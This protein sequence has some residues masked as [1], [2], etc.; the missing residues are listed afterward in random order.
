MTSIPSFYVSVEDYHSI[1]DLYVKAR[2]R[3]VFS[4]L[5]LGEVISVTLS[6]DGDFTAFYFRIPSLRAG[7]S[8]DDDDPRNRLEDEE[9]KIHYVRFSGKNAEVVLS[10]IKKTFRGEE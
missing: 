3:P 1:Q 9:E 5:P 4:H 10:I 8:L 7:S 2:L 6:K